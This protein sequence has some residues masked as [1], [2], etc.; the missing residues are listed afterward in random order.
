DET[1]ADV[2]GGILTA[3]EA[4]E[5]LLS[6]QIS[7]RNNRRLPCAPPAC[8]P[9]SGSRTSTSPSSPRSAASRSR[10]CTSSAS[11][12][13]RRTSSCWA[14][15]RRQDAAGD[16]PRGRR[17]PIRSSGLLRY[18]GQPCRIAREAK[19]AGQLARR[20]WVLEPSCPAHR[21]RDRLPAG[22]P[23]APSPSTSSSTPATSTLR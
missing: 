20:L 11:S 8:P 9:S 18:P 10:A 4:I 17:R 13:A 23:T 21:R 1:L 14:A 2:D 7:L 5:R 22:Q 12:S 16:Q 15:R 3:S 6:V 19:A